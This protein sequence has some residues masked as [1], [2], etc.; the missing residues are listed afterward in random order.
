MQKNPTIVTYV[1]IILLADK[2][3]QHSATVPTFV[4]N[5][6]DIRAS[7]GVDYTLL[8]GANIVLAAVYGIALHGT[9]TFESEKGTTF[10]VTLPQTAE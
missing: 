7:F 6:G 5:I 9:I 1:F 2:V 10:T 3:V 4:S 8:I